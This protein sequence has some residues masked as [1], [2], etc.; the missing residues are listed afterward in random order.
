MEPKSIGGMRMPVPLLAFGILLGASLL[1]RCGGKVTQSSSPGAAQEAGVAENGGAAGAPG[2]AGGP[3]GFGGVLIATGG[4][5]QSIP[6]PTP[7][8][9]A[10][11]PP[12]PPSPPPGPTFVPAPQPP[13]PAPPPPVTAHPAP[14]ATPAQP[15]KPPRPM[16]P[17]GP[18][19]DVSMCQIPPPICVDALRVE[20]FSEPQCIEGTCWSIGN[21][22]AC[23]YGCSNGA[24]MGIST[25]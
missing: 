24:C 15:P 19:A 22:E 1:V 13:P 8:P 10:P 16:L 11:P 5:P 23:P 9:P 12:I 25:H 2:A 4:V 14:P 6:P 18:C 3:H 17:G 7:W 21:F 20:Y